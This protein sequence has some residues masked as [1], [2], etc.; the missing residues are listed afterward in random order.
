MVSKRN[1]L[2]QGAIFRFGGNLWDDDDDDDDDDN[3][4]V[5]IMLLMIIINMVQHD[6]D[7]DSGG[8]G[9]TKDDVITTCFAHVLLEHLTPH[10]GWL[11]SRNRAT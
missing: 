1:L 4:V 9:D 8:G 6:D 5:L 7:N 3:D 11:S 2:C 10:N